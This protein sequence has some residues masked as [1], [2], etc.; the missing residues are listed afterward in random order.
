VGDAHL[1]EAPRPAF[2]ALAPGGWRD[3]VT[4]LHLPYTAWHLAYVVIG[5]SLAPVLHWWPLGASLAAFG[6][7]VGIGAHALDELHGRPLATTIPDPVLW[8]AAGLSLAGAVAIGIV[9]AALWTL[10]L[11]PL[12]AAGGFIVVAYNLELAGGRFHTDHWFALSWGALPVLA[13]Y[14][15][16]TG[17]LR[18]DAGLAALFAILLSAAQRALSTEVR[19]V[20]RRVTDVEGS[21]TLVDGS[22]V[23]L[24]RASLLRGQ[25]GALRLLA[26]AVVVLAAALLVL[27]LAA[28]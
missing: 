13:A 27:R 24:T 11:L 22:V 12:V 6:L 7:A 1:S 5:A 14:L 26:A 16:Q 19:L 17:R 18:W 9:S 28:A 20:R 23:P 10:W 21:L 25:E 2:Y 15:A 8:A 3:W 4:L